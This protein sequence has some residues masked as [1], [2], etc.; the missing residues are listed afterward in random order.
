MENVLTT[1]MLSVGYKHKEIVS[2]INI[3]VK[4]GEIV[5]MIGPNGTGKS[6]IL[7]T[8]AGL[9]K[10][11]SGTV[12]I[13]GKDIND[14]RETELAQHVSILMTDRVEPE[15]MTGYDIVCSGR[16]PYTGRLGILS[17]KDRQVVEEVMELVN[18]SNLKDSFF[19]ELSD[20]QKQRFMLA[21]AI[22]QEPDILIMDEPMTFLDIKYKREL[23]EII[24]RLKEE[25]KISIIM[26]LH[27]L[28]L[29]KKF[30]DKVVCIKDGGVDKIGAIDEIL[31]DEYIDYL[32]DIEK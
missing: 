12:N 15:L 10:S 3:E 22:C 11:L 13:C 1:N 8:L 32:F 17:D 18:I 25:K 26:S 29:I 20:G 24:L 14:Y 30:T 27:E 28:H 2:K 4:K 21:R 23:A 19:R 31:N 6:T 7:R 5:T 16:Y 9:Q